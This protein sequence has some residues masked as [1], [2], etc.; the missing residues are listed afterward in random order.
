MKDRYIGD[1]IL[2]GGEP[3]PDNRM[4]FVHEPGARRMLRVMCGEKECGYITGPA[5]AVLETFIQNGMRLYCLNGTKSEK[6]KGA[7]YT[8]KVYYTPEKI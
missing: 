7:V 8:V 6:E 3:E 4:T 1:V 5:A 2:T